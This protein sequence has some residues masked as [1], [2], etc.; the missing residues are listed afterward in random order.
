VVIQALFLRKAYGPVVAVDDVSLE[1]Q[2]GENFC[3]VGPNGAGKTTTIECLEGLRQPD[4]FP[5][6][7]FYGGGRAA[8]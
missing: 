7:P 2:A 6:H 5:H 1:I 8:V 4:R 3:L